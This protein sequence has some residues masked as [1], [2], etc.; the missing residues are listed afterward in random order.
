M[1]HGINTRNLS[2]RGPRATVAAVCLSCL[3]APVVSAMQ[4][5]TTRPA[6][7]S[8]AK[9]TPA[10]AASIDPKIAADFQARLEG[11]LKLRETLAKRLTPLS[12]TA[13]AADLAARQESLAAA[14]RSERK[15]ARQ[16][17][18]IP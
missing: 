3:C 18:L 2:R 10:V 7:P 9:A 16:G 12:P 1:I 11:S 4:S 13:S 8:A 6:Q 15:N 5:A 17:D 14:I